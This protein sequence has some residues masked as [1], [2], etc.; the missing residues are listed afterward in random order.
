MVN[1]LRD[2]PMGF[3]MA[4]AQNPEAMQKFST[5]T[6]SEQQAILAKTHAVNSK[7]EMQELV[8]HIAL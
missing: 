7:E 8:S 3:G 6:D 4:L 2:L 1:P 5:M